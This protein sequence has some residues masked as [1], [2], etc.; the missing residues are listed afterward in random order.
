MRSRTIARDRTASF[1]G[2]S[3]P[4]IPAGGAPQR[5]GRR[6][7]RRRSATRL[8]PPAGFPRENRTRRGRSA[9]CRRPRPR[10]RGRGPG[11][12]PPRCTA[13]R[14]PRSQP[15][16]PRARPSSAAATPPRR[17]ATRAIGKWAVAPAAALRTVAL[18]PTERR[19]GRTIASAPAHSARAN[20]RSDVVRVGDVVEDDDERGLPGPAPGER[21]LERDVLERLAEGDDAVGARD[22]ETA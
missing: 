3:V 17:C 4:R 19:S 14:P 22:T 2:V 16:R 12:G 20:D 8:G 10:S 11:Q 7:P 18:T 5:A 21:L 1:G 13:R 15:P 6:P 9:R